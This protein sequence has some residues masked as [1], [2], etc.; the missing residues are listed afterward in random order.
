VDH[1]YRHSFP[2]IPG[3]TSITRIQ[4]ARQDTSAVQREILRGDASRVL[5]FRELRQELFNTSIFGEPGWEILLALYV[6]DNDRRRLS[7]GQL[8]EV[9]NVPLTTALRWLTYLEE[10]D[11]IDRSSSGFDQRV[12]NIEL[13]EN[14]RSC[15]DRY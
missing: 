4:Q 12:V 1:K 11:L 14:G 9:S 10:Q 3:T 7:I 5:F 8:S 15:L 13:S 6:G 2:D